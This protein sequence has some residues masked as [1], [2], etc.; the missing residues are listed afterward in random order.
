MQLNCLTLDFRET[1]YGIKM[2]YDQMDTTLA[3]ICLCYM[4]I[5]RSVF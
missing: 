1:N 5:T 4:M 3:D 2:V